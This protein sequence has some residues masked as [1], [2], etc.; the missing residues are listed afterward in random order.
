MSSQ[1]VRALYDEVRLMYGR[2]L[3][4]YKL[5]GS[6]I[7]VNKQRWHYC[8]IFKYFFGDTKTLGCYEISFGFQANGDTIFVL[9]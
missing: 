1:V 3:L 2:L 5:R 6:H 9:N 7:S 4:C 8:D